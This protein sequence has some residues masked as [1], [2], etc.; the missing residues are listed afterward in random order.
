MQKKV[1][2]DY[3][4]GGKISDIGNVKVYKNTIKEK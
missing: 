4:L 1:M 2:N 3:I